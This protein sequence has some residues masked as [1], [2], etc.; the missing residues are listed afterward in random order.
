MTVSVVGVNDPPSLTGV[1]ASKGFTEAAGAVTLSGF[2]SVADVD[3]LKLASATVSIVGGSFAG[4]GDVLADVTT[5]LITASYNSATET[6]VLTGSDTLADYQTEL[7]QLTFNSTS[8]NPT[9]F[10][11]NL[12][13]T[14]TWVLND[15]SSSF[16]TSSVVTS[17]INVTAVNNPPTLTGTAASVS[18]TEGTAVTLSGAVSVGDPDNLGLQGAT[19]HITGGT[20]QGT[21]TATCWR[22]RPPAR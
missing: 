1:A 9:N 14:V 13:R 11:S 16:N 8:L 2:V 18:F 15:G 22:P 19:V 7:E 5:G 4:D 10:G 20:G 3:N 6:L 12:T 17:T 21:W